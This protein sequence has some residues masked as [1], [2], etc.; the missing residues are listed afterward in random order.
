M[1]LFDPIVGLFI[2]KLFGEQ[3]L[4]VLGITGIITVIRTCTNFNNVLAGMIEA[5]AEEEE[6]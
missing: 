3:G 1:L 6:N 4:W 2:F 5:V